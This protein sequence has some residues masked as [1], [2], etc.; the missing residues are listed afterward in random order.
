MKPDK[1][2]SE[3]FTPQAQEPVVAD[4]EQDGSLS[5]VVLVLCLIVSGILAL[6][7]GPMVTAAVVTHE[8]G[9]K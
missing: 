5:I 2:L 7:V 8:R 6:C 1:K 3:L 9:L 4:T